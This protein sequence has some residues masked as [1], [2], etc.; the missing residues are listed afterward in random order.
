MYK[1]DLLEL[2]EE[3]YKELK[4]YLKMLYDIDNVYLNN[5]KIS[6]NLIIS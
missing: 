3:E 4:Q 5:L 2:T 6:N 1:K